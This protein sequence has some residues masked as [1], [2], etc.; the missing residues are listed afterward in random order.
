VFTRV[1]VPEMVRHGYRTTFATGT[2][3]GSSV[4]GM[5]IPPSLLMIIYGVL[6]E[7]SIGKLFIAGVIPGF[8]LAI[9]FAV[10]IMLMARFTPAKVFD[11]QRQADLARQN[12]I[13]I[14]LTGGQMATKLVPIAALV[15]LVLG[16]LYSGF[17]TPTEA[18]GVGAFGALV[19]A[20]M[21]RS[22]GKG[23]LWRVLH[24]T[25]SVSCTILIL[26][27]A[28]AFYSR[29]LSVAGV[30]VAI[31]DV[32]RDAGLGPYGFLALYIAIVLLLGMI[33]DS[34][35]ILL[36][37]TPVAAP[38][39]QA[40]GFDLI[41]FGVIT[42]L[43]VEMGLLTPPFG[44]SVFTVKSTLN[45]PKVSVESIFAGALP[46]VGAMFLVLLLVCAFPLLSTAL[47]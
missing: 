7:Q 45:D 22:L 42:V 39:A 16:G 11:L 5:M 29:M 38:I 20:L 18:G 8:L 25:G 43:A 36:I 12:H 17:F 6:A 1:A 23:N 2:V 46:F 14:T 32:V 30:P 19:I 4:L 40:F 3:A 21:R 9:V 37:M 47:I 15:A 10:M 35:S 41:H 27:V 28:A 34:S 44:I 24:E 13:D 31:A 33:L 26:L